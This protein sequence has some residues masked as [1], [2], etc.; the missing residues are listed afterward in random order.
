MF[1]RHRATA[2]VMVMVGVGVVLAAACGGG[3]SDPE[4]SP[5]ATTEPAITAPPTLSPEEQAA[6]E[7]EA[8]FEDLI[9][10]RDAYYS[11]AGDYALEEVAINSPAT[12]WNVTGQAELELSNWTV[13]WRQGELEQSGSVAVASHEISSV[14]LAQ[15]EEQ[16]NQAS[17]TSCLDMTALGY[18]EADGGAAELSYE[19]DQYQTWEMTWIYFPAPSPDAGVDEAGW[20]VRTVEV[21][22]NTPC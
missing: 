17:S 13:L 1:G 10:A 12:E 20:Y 19:P 15:S 3:G 14:D 4:P 21:S 8:T 16:A 22:R 5:S 2:M 6:A 9:A 18:M 11:N 7:I